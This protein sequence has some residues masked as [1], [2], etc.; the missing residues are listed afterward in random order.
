M[1]YKIQTTSGTAEGPFD[2]YMNSTI[3]GN[4]L[5][6]SIDKGQMLGGIEVNLDV[7]QSA[8][9]VSFIVKNMDPDCMNTVTYQIPTTTTT[10]TSTTT[11]ST[12]A[13]PATST[14][15][16]TTSTT[17]VPITTTSTTTS[18]TTAGIPSVYFDSNYSGVQSTCT[19]TGGKAWSRLRGPS[20]AVIQLTLSVNH[21][22]SALLPGATDATIFGYVN[23]TTLPFVTPAYTTLLSTTNKVTTSVP[24]VIGNTTTLDIIL[25]EDGYYDVML[26][27]ITENLANNFNSGQATLTITAVDSVPMAN[28]NYITATYPCSQTSI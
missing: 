7:T 25:S 26:R 13:A 22:V 8:N 28:G 21:F 23:D 18:T 2:I 14:T 5:T 9:L 3:I 20:G 27:Y 12:T 1:N 10:T 24:S 19:L 6:S 4:L 17:T 16:T 15:S 11:T